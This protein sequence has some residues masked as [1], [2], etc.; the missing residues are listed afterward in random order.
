MKWIAIA[1]CVI[2]AAAAIAVGYSQQ[3]VTCP[4]CHNSNVNVKGNCVLRQQTGSCS[5]DYYPQHNNL[6]SCPWCGG[7]GQMTRLEAFLD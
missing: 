4:Y 1:L 3:I 6:A 2:L 7:K 5:E